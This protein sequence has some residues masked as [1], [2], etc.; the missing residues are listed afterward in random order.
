MSA[1]LLLLFVML[2]LF[3]GGCSWMTTFF[4]ANKTADPIVVE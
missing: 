1:K 3:I 2:P 4:I